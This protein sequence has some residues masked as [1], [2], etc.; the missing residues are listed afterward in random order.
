[1][2]INNCSDLQHV[3]GQILSEGYF[4][5]CDWEILARHFLSY[6]IGKKI[7]DMQFEDIYDWFMS[8]VKG[9]HLGEANPVITG[10]RTLK[11]EFSETP[12][13]AIPFY[14]AILKRYLHLHCLPLQCRD[15]LLDRAETLMKTLVHNKKTCADEVSRLQKINPRD[16]KE[17]HEFRAAIY[18]AKKN[19]KLIDELCSYVANDLDAEAVRQARNNCLYFSGLDNLTILETKAD[20]TTLGSLNELSNKFGELPVQ[21]F[22]DALALF[23]SDKVAFYKWAEE[24]LNSRLNALQD[25]I[26][27]NQWFTFRKDILLKAIDFYTKG[28]YQVSNSIVSLQIE[29]IITDVLICL[30]ADPKGL[31]HQQIT[32]KV[33]ALYEHNVNFFDEEY[34]SFIFPVIRNRIAHGG[35]H[36]TQKEDAIMLLLDLSRI[37]KFAAE[38]PSLPINTLAQIIAHYTYAQTKEEKGKSL[39]DYAIY[40]ANNKDLIKPEFYLFQKEEDSLI[41]DIRETDVMWEWLNGDVS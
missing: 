9:C 3:V 24:Y 10:E 19:G 23:H 41:S 30:G 20:H 34:Y 18:Y 26:T 36:T 33:H 8:N 37:C 28:A 11:M 15:N 39:Y 38:E 7:W 21:E 12:K 40:I 31:E 22:Y 5:R 25:L 32:N 1:M 6:F 17:E 2:D 27:D 29:G 35:A 14:K 16:G 4:L 13:E